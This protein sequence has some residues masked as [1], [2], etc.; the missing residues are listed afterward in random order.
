MRKNYFEKLVKYMKKVYH[1]ETGLKK[2]TDARINPTYNTAQ[3]ITPVLFG[4][5]LRI[6]SFNELGCMLKENEFN[7]LFTKGLRCQKVKLS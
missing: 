6:K 3:V 7:K 4:F 1:I 2:L 5:I